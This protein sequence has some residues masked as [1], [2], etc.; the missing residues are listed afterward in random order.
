MGRCIVCNKSAGPF[1]SLHK[2]CFPAYENASRCIQHTLEDAV[3]S[4]NR[5]GE[6][7]Q[8]VE[9]CLPSRGFS[10][11]LLVTLVRRA[12]KEQ[13][14]RL[15]RSKSLNPEYANNLLSIACA[16][17]VDDRTVAPDLFLKLS[18]IEY[19]ACLQ[20]GQRPLKAFS[21]G[22]DEFGMDA[23]ESLLWVFEGVDKAGQKLPD[24]PGKWALMQTI[25]N[26]QFKRS[27]YRERELE[28][29]AQGKLAITNQ[30]IHY[31]SEAETEKLGFT[32][33]YAITPLAD[34]VRIQPVY[35][36]S[37][38]STYITGDGRFT[39]ALLQYAQDQAGGLTA[40]NPF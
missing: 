29:R 25:L 5:V 40:E 4:A 15:V 11:G 23:A 9:A 6:V 16:L 14:T 24:K 27:R 26:N 20:Q 39:Y 19:L 1:Y 35:R 10:P 21:T 34:G 31:A 8:S 33:I 30:G 2:A 18:N 32:E 13:A 28:V 7:R 22:L 36:D 37:R 17:G 3:K 38:S 12:W